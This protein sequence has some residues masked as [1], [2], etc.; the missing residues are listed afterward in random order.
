MRMAFSWPSGTGSGRVSSV[1]TIMIWRMAIVAASRRKSVFENWSEAHTQ[2]GLEGDSERLCSPETP[3]PLRAGHGASQWRMDAQ[4]QWRRL[5]GR[6]S[7]P[8]RV[9]RA[10]LPGILV[11]DEQ[12]VITDRDAHEHRVGHLRDEQHAVH[13]LVDYLMRLLRQRQ[14]DLLHDHRILFGKGRVKILHPRR[15]VFQ[16][17]H[18]VQRYVH[19]VHASHFAGRLIWLRHTFAELLKLGAK[20]SVLLLK[21]RQRRQRPSRAP[22]SVCGGSLEQLL[23]HE[24]RG[25]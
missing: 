16:S 5:D 6:S 22:V 15:L 21:L 3:S 1:G 19:A 8:L 23:S 11:V 25:I 14:L 10:D 24:G 2:P 9:N 12:A 20:R 7:A 18:L 4:Q 13:W 17:S